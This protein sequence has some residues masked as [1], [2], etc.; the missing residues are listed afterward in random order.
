MSLGGRQRLFIFID[1]PTQAPETNQSI[2]PHIASTISITLRLCGC[3]YCGWKKV[4]FWIVPSEK[5]DTYLPQEWSARASELLNGSLCQVEAALRPRT[6]EPFGF[7]DCC[8][9]CDSFVEL[10]F[11]ARS[12]W[13]LIFD[14]SAITWE[15]CGI[16]SVI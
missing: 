9:M 4:P 8:R 13:P 3:A 5:E 10:F 14:Y 6:E 11:L 16:F 15:I 1:D 7:D 12:Q 2:S